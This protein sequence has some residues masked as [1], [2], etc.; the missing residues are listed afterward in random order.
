VDSLAAHGIARAGSLFAPGCHGRRHDQR[1]ATATYR[2]DLRGE[3]QI[4]ND[5]PGDVN[6]GFYD[7]AAGQR[8]T[9]RDAAKD[10]PSTSD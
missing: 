1:R 6:A 10:L 2:D 5:D 7:D 4:G 9:R 8:C 3:L